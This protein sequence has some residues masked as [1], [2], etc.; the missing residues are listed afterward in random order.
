[1]FEIL[2]PN[3]IFLGDTILPM[4]MMYSFCGIPSIELSTN[5]CSLDGG[6]SF[7]VIAAKVKIFL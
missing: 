3:S 5:A 4:A 7:A 2:E 1:L 6:F